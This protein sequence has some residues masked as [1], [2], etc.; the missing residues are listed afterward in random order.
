VFAREKKR[1]IWSLGLGAILAF[2][3][4][5][6][7]AWKIV[8]ADARLAQVIRECA[9][10]PTRKFDRPNGVLYGEYTYEEAAAA[11]RNSPRFQSLSESEKSDVLDKLQDRY[12][13]NPEAL[14]DRSGLKGRQADIVRR[15]VEAESDLDNARFYG[16]V[17][18]FVFCLPLIW[19]FL[20]DRIREF[21]NAVSGRD[22]Q[23]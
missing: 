11:L 21:S 3:Y 22:R 13:C 12:E 20:L 14:R 8:R 4:F 17:L 16:G 10:Q 7:N 18:V 15:S 19:Y 9:Q 5:G 2:P 1:V 23:T 6:W